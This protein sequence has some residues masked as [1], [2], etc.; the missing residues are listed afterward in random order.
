MSTDGR[1]RIGF[2]PLVDAATLLVAVDSGFAKA[3]GLDVELV[4][5]VSWSNIRDRLA[6]GHYDAAHLLAPM[7]VA[8]SLGLSHVKIPLIAAFNLAMNGNA[9]TVSPD[10]HAKLHTAA[11]GDLADPAVSSEALKRVISARDMGGEE[12]L[13]FAM[14]FPFSMH[15]YQL[16]YWLA[17]GGVDPD[18][19]LRL[20]VLPPPFMVDNLAK[21]QVD[22]FCVGAPWNAVAAE[23]G[24]GVVL[25]PS[26]AIFNPSPE[27]VLAFRADSVTHDPAP[28]EALIR[29]CLKAAYFVTDEENHEEVAALLSR[30]DR[31][32]VDAQ[33]I[34]RTLRGAPVVGVGRNRDYLIFG[35]R[36]SGRPDSYQASWILAQML[37]WRQARLSPELLGLAKGV[38]EPRHFDHAIG[39]SN[40]PARKAIAAF[41]GPEF[42]ETGIRG[43]VNAFTIGAKI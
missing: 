4:R 19:D 14:T 16:R 36:Q 42:D 7:A 24:L 5:E 11:D 33:A 35:D 6:V 15:N 28:L 30:P 26:C 17:A 40:P 20:I 9:I 13:T 22:G 18:R 2:I 27:K 37:R 1:L 10:L 29:A 32:G 25:H 39:V 21:E 12:P 23:A 43:Y 34:L 31:V 8:S 38:F 41:S 3:E